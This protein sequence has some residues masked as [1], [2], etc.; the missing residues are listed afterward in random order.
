MSTT[1]MGSMGDSHASRPAAADFSRL[2]AFSLAERSMHTTCA[3]PRATWTLFQCIV[4]SMSFT[5]A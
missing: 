5:M 2:S 4:R 1:L 3:A